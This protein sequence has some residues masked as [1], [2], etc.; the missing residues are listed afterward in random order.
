M[1]APSP[2]RRAGTLPAAIIL[3]VVGL[4]ILVYVVA[5]YTDAIA[6]AN[7]QT[8]ISPVGL[9]FAAAAVS[10]LVTAWGLWRHRA[11]SRGPGRIVGVLGV[12]VGLAM[13]AYLVLL[14]SIA[15]DTAGAAVPVLGGIA[16]VAI[17]AGVVT[18]WSA[19][20]VRPSA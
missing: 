4:G 13:L 1:S 18:W 14:I 6:N 7:A 19:G 15:P 8:S 20:A 16:A 10:A 2:G 9:L 3:V 11:W 17:L 5:G 12:L